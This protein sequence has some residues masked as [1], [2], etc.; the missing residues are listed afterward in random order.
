MYKKDGHHEQGRVGEEQKGHMANIALFVQ[1]GQL[2]VAEAGAFADAG[3][4]DEARHS[5]VVR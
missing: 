1:A 3:A 2:S 5:S 4:D